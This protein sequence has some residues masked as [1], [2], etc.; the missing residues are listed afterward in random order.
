MRSKLLLRRRILL[1]WL[2]RGR[3]R[4]LVSGGL[5]NGL[6][7]RGIFGSERQRSERQPE[8]QTASRDR[9]DWRCRHTQASTPVMNHLKANPFHAMRH[10]PDVA[11]LA[12]VSA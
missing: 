4:L 8:Q 2:L 3:R 6:G 1:W 5:H 10:S 7:G 11:S 12:L 9:A